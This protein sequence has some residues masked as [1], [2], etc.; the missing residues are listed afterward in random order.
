MVSLGKC[1][2]NIRYKINTSRV[3]AFFH[4]SVAKL[5]IT[6]KRDFRLIA[7]KVYIRVYITFNKKGL[8]DSSTYF[9][10]G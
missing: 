2:L 5:K 10:L 9:L 1:T 8:V 4:G 7:L 6:L 3:S